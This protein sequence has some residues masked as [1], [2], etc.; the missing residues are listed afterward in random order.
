MFFHRLERPWYKCSHKAIPS[1]ILTV[2]DGKSPFFVGYSSINGRFSIAMLVYQRV[3]IYK[4]NLI[5]RIHGFRDVI[6]CRFNG[7]CVV[8]T[9]IY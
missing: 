7:F 4:M 5:H 1:G 6:T 2:Y 3:S 9:E 8:L